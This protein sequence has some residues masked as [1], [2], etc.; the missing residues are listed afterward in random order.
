VVSYF[1]VGHASEFS[2]MKDRV[3]KKIATWDD[4]G[5][6]AASCLLATPQD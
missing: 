3:Q 4:P 6:G 2:F 1:A 5:I